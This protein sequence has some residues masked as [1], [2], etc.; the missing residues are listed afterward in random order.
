MLVD[1]REAIALLGAAAASAALAS[2]PQAS[3]ARRQRL[4]ANLSA[5]AVG[6]RLSLEEAVTLAASHGFRGVDIGR[7]DAEAYGFERARALL[8]Q[9]NLVLGAW[10]LP[11]EYQGS[12]EE[13][14]TSMKELPV[15]A[16][17][18][19]KMGCRRFVN[20]LNPG[21]NEL[22]Y[23][24]NFARMAT[25]LREVGRVLAAN[26][27]VFG[28][29]FVG[30]KTSRASFRYPFIWN[31]SG[32]LE[33]CA[34]VGTGNM[35]VLIDSW[36][37][38]TSGGD[39]AQVRR[40]R[41]EQVVYVHVND[42]PK[43]VALDA[44][45]DQA[46]AMPMETGVIDLPSLLSALDSIGYAGPVAAEVPNCSWAAVHANDAVRTVAATMRRAWR[47]ARIPW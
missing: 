19:R 2:E 10:R 16:A 27:C 3:A 46:R 14:H 9:H 32:M 23:K 29:E 25:R 8:D 1:R 30:P 40:L 47:R 24:D 11:V 21:S 36:H 20:F 39:I 38:Y 12:D 22:A 15:H 42:A 26:G 7:A 6:I 33:L 5:G 34:A 43:H 37:W 4:F 45:V 31:L 28:M 41:P 13:F 35:G 44:Q 18:L 17:N